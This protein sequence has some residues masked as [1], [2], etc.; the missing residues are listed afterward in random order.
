MTDQEKRRID[1]MFAA[2]QRQFERVQ[3]DK[4]DALRGVGAIKSGV[5]G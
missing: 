1:A 4:R 5:R 3:N 2:H